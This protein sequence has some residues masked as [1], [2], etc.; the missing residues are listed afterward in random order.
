MS[1]FTSRFFHA[2]VVFFFFAAVSAQAGISSIS[3]HGGTF[4]PGDVIPVF[5]DGAGARNSI[6]VKGQYMD[7][8]TGVVSNDSSFSP[9]IGRRIGG[10]GSSV[11]ILINANSAPDLDAATIT[12]KFAMGQET[13]RVKAFKTQITSLLLRGRAPA[14]CRVGEIV[15]LE[16]RGTV[17]NLVKGVGGAM[18]DVADGRYSLLEKQSSSTS[19]LANFSLRCTATGQFVVKRTWFKD[20]RVS[21][22]V[23]DA[24]V[25]GA[26]TL[27]V[28]VDP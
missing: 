7:L 24:M 23:G 16:A 25:R 19:T 27:T 5:V 28:T 3:A 11:E 4:S 14:R 12:I 8:C 9:A 18:L 10:S 17:A 13:F 20:A 22:A 1:R 2:S 26:A 21:G 15:T 6:T